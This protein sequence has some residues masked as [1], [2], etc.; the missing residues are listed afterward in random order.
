MWLNEPRVWSP[1]ETTNGF[2]WSIHF[3]FPTEYQ[4][5]RRECF[6][7]LSMMYF[8]AVSMGP[9]MEGLETV[10]ARNGLLCFLIPTYELILFSGSTNF[11]NYSGVGKPISS[12]GHCPRVPSCEGPIRRIEGT[13]SSTASTGVAA[14]SFAWPLNRT[15][16]VSSSFACSRGVGGHGWPL[17]GPGWASSCVA[18]LS[19]AGLYPKSRKNKKTKIG[20]PYC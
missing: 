19:F 7:Q 13:M 10:L 11:W 6:L 1:K 17:K 3:S 12:K 20:F 15:R 14:P 16:F 4:Q 5:G 9:C 8:A 2:S 18:F